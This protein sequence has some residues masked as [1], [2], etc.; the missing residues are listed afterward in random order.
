VDTSQDLKDLVF[1]SFV[2][3]RTVYSTWFPYIIS[4]DRSHPA[5]RRASISIWLSSLLEFAERAAK[6]QTA[7]T[8]LVRDGVNVELVTVRLGELESATTQILSAFTSDEQVLLWY[9]RNQSVHGHL[10]LYF[11]DGLGVQVFNRESGVTE[12][13]T[14][15]RNQLGR[16]LESQ[17]NFNPMERLAQFQNTN[18]LL[19]A[20]LQFLSE[21]A[22][23]A[24]HLE[25]FGH[26]MDPVQ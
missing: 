7:L 18:V 15:T 3:L 24:Y 17:A 4:G 9:V 22:L 21:Q 2:G 19:S 20:P 12:K 8:A 14:I 1:A 26:A 6:R 13:C 10:S 23:D 11:H 25:L 5:M 16:V